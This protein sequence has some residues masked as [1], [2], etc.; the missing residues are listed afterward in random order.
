MSTE[1]TSAAAEIDAIIANAGGWRADTLARLRRVVS[2]ADPEISETIKWRKPSRPEGVATWVCDGNICMADLLKA[3]VRLTFPKGAGID[4]PAG[5][6]N[7]RLDS[8]SVRAID[9][10]E[11]AA[12]DEE[13]LRQIVLRAV[14]LNR[15]H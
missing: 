1:G 3:A 14:A 2:G 11:G 9:V 12:I 4:D 5:L 7:A 10:V 6:F 13:A 8:G 15:Q